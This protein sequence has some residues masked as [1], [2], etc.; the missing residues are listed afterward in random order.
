MTRTEVL[1]VEVRQYVD[2][3]GEHQTLVPRLIGQ[4][5]AARHAKGRSRRKYWDRDSWLAAYREARG[6]QE[7]GIVERLLAWAEHHDPALSVNFGMGAKD[8]SAQVA[9]PELV[10]PFFIYRGYT[11]GRIELQFQALSSTPPFDALE[12]R[13]ELQDRLNEIPDVAI[14]DDQLDKYPSFPV[15]ALAN[16]QGFDRFTDTMDWVF[17]EAS[18]AR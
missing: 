18:A 7:A 9:I 11:N 3:G 1:A 10:A 13:R 5:Q 8:P 14:V 2:E 16:T 17:A 6:E 12:T 4:T 15:A